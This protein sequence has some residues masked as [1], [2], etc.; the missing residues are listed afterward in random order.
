VRCLDT[1]FMVAVLRG[2]E[3]AQRKMSELDREGR[4]C[5]TA[6]NAFELLYGAHRSA[7]R[8]TNLERTQTLLERLDVLP[9]ELE[10]SKGAAE[11]LADLAA[12]GEAIEFRDAMIAGVARASGLTLVT[13]NEEHFARVKGLKVEPW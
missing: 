1:D 3:D 11:V 7:Q 13:R 4:Q 12:R 5:T 10:A 6:V 9:F 8:R 2:K